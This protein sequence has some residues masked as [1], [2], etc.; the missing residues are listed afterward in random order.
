LPSDIAWSHTFN[1]VSDLAAIPS[2]LAASV[3][4]EKGPAVVGLEAGG[5]LVWQKQIGD[6]A[7]LVA[8]RQSLFAATERRILS[9]NAADGSTVATTQVDPPVGGWAKAT[10][11]CID[12]DLVVLHAGGLAR[13]DAQ[14]LK[15]QWHVALPLDDESDAIQQ[16]VHE[17]PWIAAVSN[18]TVMVI[19]DQ[20]KLA[21]KRPLPQDTRLAGSSALVLA[22]GRIWVGLARMSTNAR[23]LYELSISEGMPVTET[24]IPDLAMFCNAHV[25]SGV[26]VLNTEDGLAGFVVRNALSRSWSIDVPVALGQCVSSNG[27]LL[28]ASRG[29]TLLRVAFADGSKET[30]T[31]LPRKLAWVPPAPDLKPGASTRSAGS[32]EDLA[33]L[34]RGVA[35]SVSWSSEQASILFRPL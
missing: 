11:L 21:W 8:G 19:S 12:D 28:V 15:T 35:F 2:G 32:I 10:T 4:S 22:Q 17:P 6:Q 23:F 33:L 31:E 5:R 30:L 29:G 27:Q 20:G 14:E 26:L 24:V 9:I 3:V 1:A 13:L 18:R 16:L 7:T 34:P 25:S